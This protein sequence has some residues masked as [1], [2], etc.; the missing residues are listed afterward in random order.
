MIALEGNLCHSIFKTSKHSCS[1]WVDYGALD[2]QCSACICV[3]YGS[4]R[5][6]SQHQMPAAL[7]C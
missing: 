4:R 1:D 7:L 6:G 2:S 5:M 3:L